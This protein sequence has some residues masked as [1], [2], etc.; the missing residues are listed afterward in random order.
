MV[1]PGQRQR[2]MGRARAALLVAALGLLPASARAEL[3]APQV[4]A[5]RV[6]SAK[7]A[8][9]GD[10]SEWNGSGATELAIAR[11]EQVVWRAS[12]GAWSG[13]FDASCRLWLGWDEVDLYVG[14]QVLDDC[15]A[16][17][18]ARWHQGDT[19]ELFLN[20]VDRA[21]TWGPDDFQIMLAPTWAE[22]PW[23]VYERGPQGAT[24]AA[25]SGG[26][27]G[28]QLLAR[29][30]SDGYRFEARIPWG[31]F[32]SLRPAG[33]ERLFVNLAQTDRDAAGVLESY[34][35]WTGEA[36]PAF[37]ADRRGEL[38]LA[39]PVPG[40]LAS[41]RAATGRRGVQRYAGSLILAGLYALAL[42]TRSLWRRRGAKRAGLIG[43][44]ALLLSAG[45]LSLLARWTLARPSEAPAARLERAWRDFSQLLD[46]SVLGHPEPSELLAAATK[47]LEGKAV[48]APEPRRFLP[49]RPEEWQ[50]AAER[51]T[52][53]RAIPY[54]PL[55][56]PASAD[57][58]PP[59]GAGPGAG[60]PEARE[61]TEWGLGLDPGANL[62]LRLETAQ[63]V[64]GVHLVARI[65]DPRF[66]TTNAA[67]VPLLQIEPLLGDER[68]GLPSS[69]RH[70]RDLHHQGGEHVDRPGLELAREDWNARG[71][72]HH[73]DSLFIAFDQ[74]LVID[75]VRLSHV[76][77]GY[78][79]R[80]EAL[81]AV[82]SGAAAAGEPA[83]AL[84]PPGLRVQPG[85]EWAWAG[86]SH[87]LRAHVLPL[88]ARSSWTSAEGLVRPLRLGSQAVGVVH[89]ELARSGSSAGAWD[90][91]PV[92]ALAVVTP[93]L[94]ALFA[95]WLAGL[96]RL[97]GKLA[98][99]FAASSALPLVAMLVLLDA[100]IGSTHEQRERERIDLALDRAEADLRDAERELQS[101]AQ[102]LLEIAQ[103]SERHAGA[104]P[105]TPEELAALWGAGEG[106]LRILEHTG[107]EGRR[108]RVGSGV[109]WAAV[110]TE[111]RL[112]GGLW[113]PWGDLLVC[114]LAQTPAGST[115]SMSAWVALPAPVFDADA[116]VRHGVRLLGA[117]RDGPVRF[118]DLTP[119]DPLESRRP[120]YSGTQGRELSAVLAAR[121]RPRG[122][123][124]LGDFTL[125][126]LLLGA[127][128]SAVFTALL[129]AGILTAHI[130]GP[131][132]RLD[133][134]IRA[135]HARFATR[136]TPDE[137]GSLAGAVQ[138][139]GAQLHRRL[140]QLEHLQ[141][142]QADIARRLD[143][144]AART[145]VLQLFADQ[146]GA[147]A[148]ALAWSGEAGEEPRAFTARPGESPAAQ[149]IPF[150]AALLREWLA[151]GVEVAS[152][153]EELQSREGTVER[154]L[155]GT[156]RSILWLPLIAAGVSRGG[157][158][159]GFDEKGPHADLA[160]LRAA[161]GQAASALENARLYRQAVVD[162]ITD[163]L[164]EPSFRARVREE[165]QRAQGQGESGVAL[166]LV[167]L[168]ELP[169]D[170]R[171]AAAVLREVAARCRA[172]LGGQWG[173]VGR[174]G[175]ADVALAQPWTGE[176]PELSAMVANLSERVRVAL[177]ALAPQSHEF[178]LASAA[179]PDDGPSAAGCLA[180]LEERL[181]P[182]EV[183]SDGVH[184][185]ME[186]AD[187]PDEIVAVSPVYVELLATV[188]RLAQR[189]VTVWI[190]G[191]TGVGKSTLAELVH[192]LSPR[193][194]APLVNLHCPSLSESLIEDELFGHEKGAFTGAI[195][196]RQSPFEYAR[197][198]TVVLD[199]VAGLPAAGQAALLRI[200]E[201]GEVRP[202]GS[203]RS[204]A[205][206]VRVV[207]TST[208]NLATA[209]EQG[210]FRRDLYFRLAVAQVEVPP[211]R[212]RRQALPALIESHLRRFN[213]SAALP[214]T[215]VAAEA[216]DLLFEH[217]WPGNLRELENTLQRGFT[218]AAGGIL[219]LEHLRL[220]TTT[221]TRP[222]PRA[223][224]G[225]AQLGLT[226]R[227]QRLLAK[228]RAGEVVSS[229]VYAE[230]ASVSPR[231]A[232]RDLQELVAM[233]Y[234]ERHG[235]K[236]GTRFI[237][238]NG[239]AKRSQAS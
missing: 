56:R 224:P 186:H 23:G 28:V 175:P 84:P 204:I 126:E 29:E 165:A 144:D 184:A 39:S 107:A 71:G 91:L 124:V 70:Q 2:E 203:T 109:G 148:V 179:W 18:S 161:A 42:A 182:R 46:P 77:P 111:T 38:I 217:P 139:F 44:L 90:F 128:L 54:R 168:T 4:Q 178:A 12:D 19:L 189:D 51:R 198:G 229:T 22:R 227:Q 37:S 87:E 138:A 127:G 233:G 177:A 81:S 32:G 79:V 117:G 222:V 120:V 160:F 110:P 49:L 230:E 152:S 167:R 41:T 33:G 157:L 58:L 104:P 80:L 171:T 52:A 122:V 153:R 62:V 151:G 21:E 154:A 156:S 35:T 61:R 125:T 183:A 238:G 50:F 134:A 176:R 180:K 219:S 191:E 20:L 190:R 115:S 47:L 11:A 172:A 145:A 193:R 130:A 24:G 59:L 13:P 15:A 211:L 73:S 185:P 6:D 141:V 174:T 74:A 101:Q 228:L 85:G 100:A 119:P 187:L 83:E 53:E 30:F 146:S 75:G 103:W 95:E 36:G 86:W 201:Q 45:V 5:V 1:H 169:G 17:D 199:E 216:M 14:G 137:V 215:G 57:P 200:L 106:G 98:V 210:T 195:A 205:V 188:R 196:R 166:Y 121:Q 78:S 99:A 116:E 197:G 69:V 237:R 97:R 129:F 147:K 26:F 131:I 66:F 94:V 209:V 136:E 206:D 163:A 43:A 10:P 208:V 231:T 89:L 223:E 9:D 220:D 234:L 27:G 232:L 63:Q 164:T 162:P 64:G 158:L 105:A 8:L 142:A 132:E 72:G 225:L 235:S 133:R 25:S 135:G 93:F 155:M 114:G 170:E 239:P 108:V 181:L 140:G 218:M 150:H 202:L 123:P 31:N 92:A 48:P 65:D 3:L 221:P 118:E 82:L 112:R 143:M 173:F 55:Q 34:A 96:R 214:V 159:L 149:W 60:V 213:A 7:V 212:Q 113:R 207:A 102:A 226:D 88:G 16:F 40:A 192:R 194:Q 236:R 67:E 68:L 76:G